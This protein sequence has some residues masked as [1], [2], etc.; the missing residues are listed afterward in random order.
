MLAPCFHT[1]KGEKKEFLP[2]SLKGKG[3]QGYPCLCN[4]TLSLIED[5]T[6]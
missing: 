2:T 1:S 6:M 3:Q 5:R 4:L